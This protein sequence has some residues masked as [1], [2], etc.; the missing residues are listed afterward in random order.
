M[1]NV[2]VSKAYANF[3]FV[4]NAIKSCNQ[5]FY[6]NFYWFNDLFDLSIYLDLIDLNQNR[7]MIQ[8]KKEFIR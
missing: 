3:I 6:V 2:N 8:T 7:K 5:I 4:Y 1:I